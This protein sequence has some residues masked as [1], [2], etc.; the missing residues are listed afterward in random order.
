MNENMQPQSNITPDEAAAS[1]S[2]ATMLSEGL[3]PKQATQQS[4][5]APQT[6]EIG[7][8]ETLNLDTPEEPEVDL[9]AKLE[10]FKEEIKQELN[11]IKELIKPKKEEK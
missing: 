11:E 2:F 5:E 8:E 4:A 1:L 10:S 3:M 6:P 9:D 7:E